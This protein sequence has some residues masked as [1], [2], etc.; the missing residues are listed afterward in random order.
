MNNPTHVWNDRRLIKL[1]EKE[2]F[3]GYMDA[4]LRSLK[5]VRNDYEDHMAELYDY[6]TQLEDEN[7]RLKEGVS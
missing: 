5:E 4:V 2:G 1:V 6:I 7:A 3:P